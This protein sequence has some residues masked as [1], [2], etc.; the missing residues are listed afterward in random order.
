M[1]FKKYHHLQPISPETQDLAAVELDAGRRHRAVFGRLD[2]TRTPGLHTG[3]WHA[4]C[5][6]AR[7]PAV[8]ICCLVE[9]TTFN[10]PHKD[11]AHVEV[12]AGAFA[13]PMWMCG[14]R[15]CGRSP[16]GEDCA[17]TR[18]G[19]QRQKIVINRETRF[20]CTCT[21]LFLGYLQGL[22]LQPSRLKEPGPTAQASTSGLPIGSVVLSWPAAAIQRRLR[23]AAQ[24]ARPRWARLS[25]PAKSDSQTVP[26]PGRWLRLHRDREPLRDVARL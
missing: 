3:D 8:L 15:R 7:L 2:S 11:D 19:P 1:P 12:V 13:S 18:F 21:V 23:P 4:A 6:R 20:S 22:L 5:P 26:T 24:R 16:C 10:F 9:T 25:R 17:D 14:W